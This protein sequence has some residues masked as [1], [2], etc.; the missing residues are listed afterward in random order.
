M[1]MLARQEICR[2]SMMLTS[3][4]SVNLADDGT[5]GEQGKKM[6]SEWK[7]LT[8]FHH[9]RPSYDDVSEVCYIDIVEG[10]VPM[11]MTHEEAINVKDILAQWC[12]ATEVSTHDV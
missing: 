1:I 5:D 6:P 8:I 11:R 9:D 10:L 4:G 2:L 3:S 12:G 7:G